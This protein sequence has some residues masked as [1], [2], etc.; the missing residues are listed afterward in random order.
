MS[1]SKQHD[2]CRADNV[3][4]CMAGASMRGSI[5]PSSYLPN[6]LF[7]SAS[8]LVQ[9]RPNLSLFPTWPEV[10]PLLWITVL[11]HDEILSQRL[12]L[13]SVTGNLEIVLSGLVP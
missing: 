8:G 6:A 3:C 2:S 4:G 11:L 7:Y 12:N 1:K 10:Y 5:I 9:Q 13:V